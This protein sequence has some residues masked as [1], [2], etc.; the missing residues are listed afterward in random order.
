MN[1]FVS[2]FGKRRKKGD[3]AAAAAGHRQE[4]KAIVLV[5]VKLDNCKGTK[6]HYKR[7]EEKVNWSMKCWNR[8]GRRFAC[9]C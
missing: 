8:S 6:R 9:G 5:T 7:R 2:R 3:P 4:E 1:S